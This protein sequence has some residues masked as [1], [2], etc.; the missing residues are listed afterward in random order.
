ML[1]VVYVNFLRYK[2]KT[3]SKSNQQYESH[4]AELREEFEIVNKQKQVSLMDLELRNKQLRELYAKTNIL[5]KE[6]NWVSKVDSNSCIN[7]VVDN[8]IVLLL[9]KSKIQ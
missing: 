2:V 6:I 5:Q 3:I 4:I 8:D 7:A 1:S 9:Q